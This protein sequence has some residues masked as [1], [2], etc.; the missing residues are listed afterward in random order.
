MEEKSKS[1]NLAKGAALVIAT[2]ALTLSAVNYDNQKEINRKLDRKADRQR[3]RTH[4][5]KRK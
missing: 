5:K 1:N 3:T 4:H 2:A